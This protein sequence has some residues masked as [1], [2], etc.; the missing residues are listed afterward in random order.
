MEVDEWTPFSPEI[1]NLTLNAKGPR[2]A[3]VT[4]WS[5]LVVW[6]T[7]E[8]LLANGGCGHPLSAYW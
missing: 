8:C 3:H 4:T 2:G 1:Y 6:D 5:E 7:N